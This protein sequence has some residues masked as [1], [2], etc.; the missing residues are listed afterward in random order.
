MKKL[1]CERETE[2]SKSAQRAKEG[3]F[4]SVELE[5]MCSVFRMLSEP[6]RLKIVLALLQGDMC[7]YHLMEVCDGTQSGV[8]HQLR[9]LRDNRV[10][11]ATRIGQSVEYSIA[12]SHI[13]EIVEKG[14]EHI[15][16]SM[17][18]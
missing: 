14:I 6:T 15:Q 17:E 16:C 11:K 18:S 7:V 10:V 13:R 4:S 2:H 5:K 9:V 8:S 3:I 1:G 12:D